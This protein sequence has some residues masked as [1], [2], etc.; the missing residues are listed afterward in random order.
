MVSF[1][2]WMAKTFNYDMFG[3]KEMT[4]ELL[5]TRHNVSKI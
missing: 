2:C 4:S 3:E 1:K 5:I